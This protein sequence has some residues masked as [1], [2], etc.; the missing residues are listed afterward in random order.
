[1]DSMDRGYVFSHHI[2][3]LDLVGQDLRYYY[4]KNLTKL[5]FNFSIIAK[6]EFVS[7]PYPGI[8]DRMQKEIT[9]LTPSTM[10]TTNIAPHST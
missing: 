3:C 10:M 7:P 1:M 2:L 4:M 6:H 8:A 9:T 5:C